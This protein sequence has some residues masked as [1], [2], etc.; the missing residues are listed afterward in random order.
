MSYTE[1]EKFQVLSILERLVENNIDKE[2]CILV[3]VSGLYNRV[4]RMDKRYKNAVEIK[5]YKE[6]LDILY[7]IERDTNRKFSVYDEEPATFIDEG[8]LTYVE[9]IDK[10]LKISG[11]TLGTGDFTNDFLVKYRPDKIKNKIDIEI[12]FDKGLVKKV[13]DGKSLIFRNPK[14]SKRFGFIKQIYR[15]KKVKGD[16]LGK[17]IT[18]TSTEIKTIN[19]NLK[20]KL[21]LSEDIIINHGN[22]GYELN[23]DAYNIKSK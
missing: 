2:W 9:K 18:N 10:V 17:D 19:T 13:S 21:Y 8:A 15:D 14:R 1:S 5:N 12:D 16:K 20:Q 6:I 22:S 7:A 4:L 11:P 3:S 23:L